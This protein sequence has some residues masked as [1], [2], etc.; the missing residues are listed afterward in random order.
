MPV[1][2]EEANINQEID[3]KYT[4]YRLAEPLGEMTNENLSRRQLQGSV[5]APE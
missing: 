2:L 4:G 3:I 1:G 5:S